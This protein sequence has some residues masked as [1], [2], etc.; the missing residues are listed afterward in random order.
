MLGE[1]GIDL[2]SHAPQLLTREQMDTAG[3]RV[4]MGCLDDESC[5]AHL[6]HLAVRDWA[7]EDPGRLDDL[8]F[9]RVRDRIVA[10]V[11]ELRAE[12]LPGDLRV[13]G[14]SRRAAP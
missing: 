3:I 5:P 6:R 12:L 7:L 4:T 9:R 13:E 10:R 8:G 11:A 2:P 14:S 1:L